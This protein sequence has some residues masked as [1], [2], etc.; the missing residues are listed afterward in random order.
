MVH[1][2]P[3]SMVVRP[4][5]SHDDLHLPP[6]WHVEFD[7]SSRGRPLVMFV[8]PGDV[9][10]RS[11]TNVWALHHKSS[12]SSRRERTGN[13][14][15]RL[16]FLAAASIACEYDVPLWRRKHTPDRL[17]EFF[18]RR[19][20]HALEELPNRAKRI[21]RISASDF[22]FVPPPWMLH[23]AN[24]V[25]SSEIETGMRSMFRRFGERSCCAMI[26]RCLGSEQAEDDIWPKMVAHEHWHKRQQAAY[27]DDLRGSK[28]GRKRRAKVRA[29]VRALLTPPFIVLRGLAELLFNTQNYEVHLANP[30]SEAAPREAPL[31]NCC[32]YD[33]WLCTRTDSVAH[34]ATC[35]LADIV[36]WFRDNEVL[37]PRRV[38]GYDCPVCLGCFAPGEEWVSA[39]P[40]MHYMHKACAESL[41]ARAH[42]AAPTC[43]E[44]TRPVKF[45][46]DFVSKRRER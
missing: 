28:V 23:D 19:G 34:V 17:V 35:I 22:G 21:E 4:L 36:L 29:R 12:R 37:P 18:A 14:Q 26:G 40:C 44:C 43:L 8:G 27:A 38:G 41:G 31:T 1:Q 46:L 15:D 10:E 9:Y 11:L 42:P 7:Y 2:N 33:V 39:H 5:T 25:C 24:V 32:A 3:R 6:G 16:D 30:E 13:A 45:F 20:M